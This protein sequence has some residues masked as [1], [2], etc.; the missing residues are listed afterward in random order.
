MTV[1][2]TELR[3]AFE[4]WC[5]GDNSAGPLLV[6]EIE[7]LGRQVHSRPPARRQRTGCERPR[8]DD[9]AAP[10]EPAGPQTCG[11]NPRRTPSSAS[12]CS[13]RP[14]CAAPVKPGWNAPSTVHSMTTSA[15][16]PG[17]SRPT[18]IR[19]RTCGRASAIGSTACCSGHNAS[20]SWMPTARW[21]PRCHQPGVLRGCAGPA[22][23]AAGRLRGMGQRPLERLGTR[24]MQSLEELAWADRDGLS[25]QTITRKLQPEL[26]EALHKAGGTR[27]R[28]WRRARVGSEFL[29][30][31]RMTKDE[32]DLVD[33]FARR[34][35][36]DTGSG[37]LDCPQAFADA[38]PPRGVIHERPRI[39]RLHLS[40]TPDDGTEG[41]FSTET[42]RVAVACP[43]LDV[44]DLRLERADRFSL[45]SRNGR[46][47]SSTRMESGSSACCSNLSSRSMTAQG[48]CSR[49]G[50]TCSTEPGAPF[51]NRSRP[52][53][54]RRSRTLALSHR[55]F[56][57]QRGRRPGRRCGRGR[58]GASLRRSHV[59]RRPP[60]RS[61]PRC[62]VPPGV[63]DRSG[64]G[65][66]GRR[67]HAHCVQPSDSPRLL[68]I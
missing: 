44:L 62:G 11:C 17:G 54:A 53:H 49:S 31:T 36:I 66:S 51:R 47:V 6:K 19:A 34:S 40:L 46:G 55:T 15:R 9:A 42:T 8:P 59:A 64:T 28:A 52:R 67:L 16:S 33:E 35:T 14:P 18:V 22:G 58:P 20:T 50:T 26:D 25:A 24:N 39:A 57:R 5:N 13:A 2:T 1:A 12:A 63:V 38:S 32:R 3:D 56:G 10:L 61:R 21:Q 48:A 4:A 37:P 43:P 68:R 45:R 41:A 30:E 23:A 65:G 7:V 27:G 29:E 60:G